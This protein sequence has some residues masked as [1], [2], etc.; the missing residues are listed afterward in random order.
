MFSLCLCV[1]V[2]RLPQSRDMH[3]RLI[4]HSNLPIV[5]CVCG[6]LSPS[7]GETGWEG[8]HICKRR[9]NQTQNMFWHLMQRIP[10]LVM[11][12]RTKHTAQHRCKYLE[13]HAG[14]HHNGSEGERVWT[15]GGDHDGG[16]VGMDH[17]GPRCHRVRCASCRRRNDHTWRDTR[18]AV[19]EGTT[20]RL[21]E[22]FWRE[23][24]RTTKS[25][26]VILH[27]KSIQSKT[28][29]T[30]INQLDAFENRG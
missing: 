2:L 13:L 21:C 14:R 8:S 10:D 3:V 29:G 1:R 18:Y 25:G 30:K 9:S 7:K 15:D 4:G 19:K 11:S 24:R 27:N 20:S 23:E 28:Y 22:N 5:A 26:K 6:C 16:D 12:A 17:R